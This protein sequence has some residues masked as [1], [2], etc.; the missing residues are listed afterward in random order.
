MVVLCLH[1]HH[2]STVFLTT[3]LELFFILSLALPLYLCLLF[4]SHGLSTWFIMSLLLMLSKESCQPY[5]T[6]PY[7]CVFNF[8]VFILVPL[9]TILVLKCV[10]SMK[11]IYI[12]KSRHIILNFPCNL[13]H[14]IDC[15]DWQRIKEQNTFITSGLMEMIHCTSTYISTSEPKCRT[16]WLPKGNFGSWSQAESTYPIQKT[17]W[18]AKVEPSICMRCRGTGRCIALDVA[19]NN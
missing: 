18:S 5:L 12:T 7:H 8:K 15:L 9:T 6:C 13:T 4:A 1:Y 17:C 2:T 11:I 16:T 10:I 19:W 3:K 14:T